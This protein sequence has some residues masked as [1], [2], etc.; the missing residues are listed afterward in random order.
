MHIDPFMPIEDMLPLLRRRAVGALEVLEL[1]IGRVEAL[2]GRLN[3]VVVRDFE[4]ARERARQLDAA[5]APAGPLHGLPMT[6]KESFDVEGLPTTLGFAERAGAIATRTAL[7]VERLERAG[8]VVFGKTNVPKALAD[9]E[10]FND[11]YGT[12]SNPFDLGCSPGGSSGGSAAAVA[13]GL[14]AIEL[15]SD[16]GGSIRQPAHACGLFGHKPTMDLVPRRPS[17][18]RLPFS[19]DIA[20]SGPLARSAGDLR[21]ALDVLAGPDEELTDLRLVLPQGPKRLAGLR[22][23]IW[24]E[25]DACPTDPLITGALLDLVPRLEAA[26]ATVSASARPAFDPAVAFGLYL[27]LM[28]LPLALGL[29][30]ERRQFVDRTFAPLLD[31]FPA[32]FGGTG[33][34]HLQWLEL[35]ARRRETQ[36]LY[37]S[38]FGEWDVLLCPAFSVPAWPHMQGE[39]WTRRLTVNGREIA[40][41]HQLFWPGVIGGF[42]LPATAVPL[43]RTAQNRP[44]G[45]QVVGPLYADHV[46]I[47]VAA[48]L[49]RLGLA[50]VPPPDFA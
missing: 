42:H 50:F 11:V 12:T 14:S 17:P 29:D 46:T 3:A 6:V 8:A 25:D 15:G 37:R 24:A 20:A 35:D 1:F 32:P 21:L 36:R 40:Y 28:M 7:A 5:T 13:A 38:F 18:E 26:G 10:S 39:P 48:L 31:L 33:I 19:V 34:S 49:E 2:D 27:R 41:D 23:A 9:W 16:I 44:F 47:G 45:L 30:A 43:G 22:I 4:R